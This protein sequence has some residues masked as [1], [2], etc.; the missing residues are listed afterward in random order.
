MT[1]ST[2]DKETSY[3]PSR[4]L[5]ARVARFI[6][7][8]ELVQPDGHVLV[9]I[10]GGPD[11]TCLLMTL[12]ALRSSLRFDLHAGYFDHQLRGPRAAARERR[13]VQSLA[14]ALGVPLRCGSGDVRAHARGRSLEEAARELRYRFLAESA[15]EA[16]CHTIA[17]GHTRDDQAETVLLHLIRGSG[18]RGLAAIAPAAPWPVPSQAGADALRLVRPLLSLTREDTEACCREAGLTPI[19]DPS[20]RSPTFLRNRIRGEL[21]PLL[22]T[23]N[24]R[25]DE[26]LARLADAAADDVDL[27]EQ[28]A[29]ASLVEERGAA[30]TARLSRRRLGQLP[31]ALQ[32]H[33]VRLAVSHVAGSAQGLSDRHVRAVLRANSGPTGNQLDLPRG[34]LVEVR[35]DAIVFS[36]NPLDGETPLP[37]DETALPVP[38]EARFGPWRFQADLLEGPPADLTAA[39]DRHTAL[40]NAAVCGDRLWLRR[41]RRGD[42]FHPLGLAQP[43][44]LQDFFVDA[45]VPR[46]ERDA[47]PLVCSD[48]GIAWVVGQRPA[49]WA[50][51]TAGTR[52]TLRLRATNTP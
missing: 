17:V 45:H 33:A 5:R 23:Y 36:T 1:P 22:R 29:A 13:F 30:G 47:V 51:I 24:P 6:R 2:T 25:M 9:G 38:G 35:R 10:S 18:L 20:N 21:L 39:G 52:R 19:S 41:R 43:K 32:R 11:S 37:A 44:K 26:A 42:R 40:L 48:R 46:A 8:H 14:D 7:E 50:K 12:A 3:S 28:L 27:L 49:E 15:Q 34:L 16:G 4:S 31:P